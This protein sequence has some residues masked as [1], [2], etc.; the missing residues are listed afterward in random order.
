M[1][2]TRKH[3]I[4]LAE[5]VVEMDKYGLNGTQLEE[6]T[7]SIGFICRKHNHNFD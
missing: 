3:F 2:L 5:V 1:A 7:Q 6:L 4:D